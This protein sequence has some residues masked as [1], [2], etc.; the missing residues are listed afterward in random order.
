MT[1]GQY[2]NGDSR[3]LREVD[4]DI[5]AAAGPGGER[6]PSPVAE[7]DRAHDRQSQPRQGP[8]PASDAR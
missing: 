3:T 7:C 2:V 8:G 5:Q 1:R 4:G 6:D